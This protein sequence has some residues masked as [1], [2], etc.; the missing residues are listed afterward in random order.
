MKSLYNVPAP[1]KVNLF[2]HV[3]GYHFSGYHFLQTVL[4]LIDLNDILNFDV[5]SDG[6]ISFEQSEKLNNLKVETKNL[7]LQAAIVLKEKTGIHQGV[8]IYLDKNIP[9]GS[10]LGG[11]SSNAATVLISLNRLWKTNLSKYELMDL[12]LC[13]GTD[14]PFFIFGCS[15]FAEG[16]G[17]V[18]SKIS[19]PSRFYLITCPNS[20]VLTSDVFSEKKRKTSSSLINKENLTFPLDSSFGRNDLESVVHEK[21]PS[22]F[23][24]FDWLRKNGIQTR[25]SGSGACLYAEYKN[26]PD[27]I[28]AEREITDIIKSCEAKFFS[29]PDFLLI[30]ICR[31]LDEHP[32]KQWVN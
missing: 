6:I 17:E 22:V 8:H 31:G 27:A 26:L 1:A 24:A 4:R 13:L 2:L 21:Y 16:F 29:S 14:V 23:H 7:I 32:L 28:L 3:N 5:R 19:L 18:L 11:G 20:K 15:A 10:G 9:I 30:K 25:M 12:G